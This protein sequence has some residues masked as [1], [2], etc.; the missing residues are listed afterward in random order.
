MLHVH[1]LSVTVGGKTILREIS[2]QARPG[3]LT[4]LL[5]AN[6][7][8]KS[9]LLRTVSGNIT[10]QHGRVLWN[11]VDVLALPPRQ[12]ARLIAVLP[13]QS[14]L[15]PGFTVREVVHMGRTPY[16]NFLGQPGPRDEDIVYRALEQA[17]AAHLANR[18]VET[19]SGG[20]AQRVLLARA[21][22]QQ[23]PILLLDEPTTWLDLQ[24]QM[25]LLTLLRDLAT[26]ENL[27]VLLVL[28][29]LNLALRF[30]DHAVLL[31]QGRVL[32]AGAPTAVL[33]PNQ[34]AAAYGWPVTRF[35]VAG[36]PVLLPH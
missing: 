29:D 33:S 3:Q 34:V 32:T 9:T 20:E 22:A 8:G 2:L 18:A 7:A 16:L 1:N 35:E 21:L 13:Q 10:P 5:G 12:R 14:T 17:Q 15:P 31:H 26:A 23:T 27:T 24:H 36:Q 25:H 19:L 6:G 28:H 4:A 30:A 11:T